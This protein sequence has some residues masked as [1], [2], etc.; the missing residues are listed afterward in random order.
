MNP[1]DVLTVGRARMSYYFT[2]AIIETE[3]L[4][5]PDDCAAHQLAPGVH[6]IW[7]PESPRSSHSD[8]AAKFLVALLAMSERVLCIDYDDG[9]GRRNATIYVSGQLVRTFGE[10]DELWV[11]IDESGKPIDGAMPMPE[12]KLDEDVEYD[13]VHDGI[14][15]ALDTCYG[16][17]RFSVATIRSIIAVARN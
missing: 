6:L 4:T 14:T 7:Q 11:P 16:V 1:S 17:G 9:C 5:V 8:S 3:E 12:D 10:A 15:A 2:C 13:C